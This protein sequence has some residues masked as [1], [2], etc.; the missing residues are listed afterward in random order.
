[1]QLAELVPL[2]DLGRNLDAG[3]SGQQ[4]LC[5]SS[6]ST[7]C[8]RSP[9]MSGQA[10]CATQQPLCSVLNCHEVLLARTPQY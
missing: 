4:N 6:S 1:M 9:S 7:Q 10:E 5:F 3:T 2:S 8:N